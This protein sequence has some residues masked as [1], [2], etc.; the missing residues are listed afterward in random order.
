MNP[1]VIQIWPF[2][3]GLGLF[4]FG[5]SQMEES[6]RKMAGRSFT[7]FLKDHTRNPIKAVLSGALITAVLQSSAMAVS[8]THL[9]VYK[10]QFQ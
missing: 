10:R 7:K 3:A 8:Y 2:L 6:L 5:M 1:T 9:D 4:L